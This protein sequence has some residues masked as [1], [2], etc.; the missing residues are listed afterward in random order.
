MSSFNVV[1]Y[2]I[3]ICLHQSKPTVF[4]LYYFNFIVIVNHCDFICQDCLYNKND[5]SFGSQWLQN[6][7]N[8]NLECQHVLY[9]NRKKTVVLIPLA[10]SYNKVIWPYQPNQKW[11]YLLFFWKLYSSRAYIL[12]IIV[13]SLS[14]RLFTDFLK[15]YA[16]VNLIIC[17]IYK[18]SGQ[19]M[20]YNTLIWSKEP[21]K[22]ERGL[23]FH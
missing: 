12:S 6:I 4:E 10:D 22:E 14:A 17:M 3:I 13:K 16:K 5:S 18:K 19:V 15:I 9:L 23:S 7:F 2:K 21:Y 11:P 1:A 20:S 8:I